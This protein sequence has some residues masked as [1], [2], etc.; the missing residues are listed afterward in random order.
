MYCEFLGTAF[1]PVLRPPSDL[2]RLDETYH[3]SHLPGTNQMS[4]IV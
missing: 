2:D 3:K 1:E 4:A